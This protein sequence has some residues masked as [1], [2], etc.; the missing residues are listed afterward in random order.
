MTDERAVRHLVDRVLEQHSHIDALV[1]TVGGYV[2][3]V[4]LWELETPASESIPSCRGSL[5]LRQTARLRERDTCQFGE[6]RDELPLEVGIKRFRCW[7]LLFAVMPV[8]SADCRRG[9]VA[10][11]EPGLGEMSHLQIVRSSGAAHFGRH[12]ARIDRVAQ[13]I[14]PVS[15]HSKSQGNDAKLAFGVC[16]ARLPAT[17]DPIDVAQ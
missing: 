3:D 12:P 14:R 10:N 11:G 1:N 5:T 6:L 7:S 2:G 13:H 8:A 4:K 9:I 15:G 16:A 17:R